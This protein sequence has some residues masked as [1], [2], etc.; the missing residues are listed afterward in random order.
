MAGSILFQLI[1][2]D[3]KQKANALHFASVSQKRTG[4]G[5]PFAGIRLL[6]GRD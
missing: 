2:P 6:A 1:R 5:E 3:A 4:E